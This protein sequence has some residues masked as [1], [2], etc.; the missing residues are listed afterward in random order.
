MGWPWQARECARAAPGAPR[1]RWGGCRAHRAQRDGVGGASGAGC[2]GASGGA[3]GSRQG[4]WGAEAYGPGVAAH[5]VGLGPFALLFSAQLTRPATLTGERACRR[6][7][8]RAVATSGASGVRLLTEDGRREAARAA[9]LG[10]VRG[11]DSRA[12]LAWWLR[13]RGGA[14][15]AQGGA[16]GRSYRRPRVA[17][18]VVEVDP[19]GLSVQ[20]GGLGPR[21]ADR[22]TRLRVG[23]VVVVASTPN[24]R[25]RATAGQPLLR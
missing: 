21:P 19:T 7:L 9:S 14:R 5:T 10:A 24:L 16:R 8:R 11:G 2:G 18:R 25:A 6:A 12:G 1:G 20:G 17:E 13:A 4:R 3:R 22:C 15:E 23:V